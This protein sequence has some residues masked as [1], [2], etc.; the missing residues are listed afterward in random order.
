MEFQDISSIE[1]YHAHI[2]FDESTVPR[3]KALCEEAGKKVFSPSRTDAP[4][5]YRSLILVGVVS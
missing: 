2:Y 5:T 4:Q 3:A 1:K